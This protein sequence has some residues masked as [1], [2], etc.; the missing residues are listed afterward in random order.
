M[1]EFV[2]RYPVEFDASTTARFVGDCVNFRI[3][4]MDVSRKTY[5]ELSFSRKFTVRGVY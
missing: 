5:F 2:Y 1:T 4:E 3:V